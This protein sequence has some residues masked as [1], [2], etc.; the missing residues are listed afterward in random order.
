MD[1]QHR[2]RLSLPSPPQ[3]LTGDV[4]QTHKGNASHIQILHCVIVCVIFKN[5]WILRRPLTKSSLPWDSWKTTGSWSVPT[6]SCLWKPVQRHLVDGIILISYSNQLV[7]TVPWKNN[8]M[9]RIHWQTCN[10]SVLP[11]AGQ[12]VKFQNVEK[13]WKVGWAE[14]VKKKICACFFLK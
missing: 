5:K 13:C 9:L 3:S 4:R 1:R 7:T 14:P 10:G 2:A 6:K 11:S 12:G 8:L